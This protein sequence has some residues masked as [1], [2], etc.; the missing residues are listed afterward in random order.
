MKSKINAQPF[1]RSL[2]SF[3]TVRIILKNT[4]FMNK[5]INPDQIIDTGKQ[6]YPLKFIG[7]AE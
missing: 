6:I 7:T 5:K 1:A 2:G 4:N 3:P